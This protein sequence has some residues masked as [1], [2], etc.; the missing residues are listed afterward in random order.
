LV[1]VV[2]VEAVEVV[3]V[4]VAALLTAMSAAS[5][6]AVLVV[7]ASAVALAAT[8]EELLRA[9]TVAATADLLLVVTAVVLVELVE[10]SVDR[11]LEV[12]MAV[13][14]TETPLV[15]AAALGGRYHLSGPRH[16]DAQDLTSSFHTLARSI[17]SRTAEFSFVHFFVHDLLR[18]LSAFRGTTRKSGTC[19]HTPIS[20]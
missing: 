13:E 4:D 20:I 8:G 12:P 19:S 16:F 10:V 15:L 18:F 14:A 7:A 5:M 11:P 1:V 17:T 6:V 2:E 3:V 9:V